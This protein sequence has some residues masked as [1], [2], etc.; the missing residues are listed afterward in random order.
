MIDAD[1][2]ASM[3]ILRRCL[4]NICNKIIKCIPFMLELGK[5]AQLYFTFGG[6][7]LTVILSYRKIC[8]SQFYFN[9]LM[10]S[11]CLVIILMI[12]SGGIIDQI[13]ASCMLISLRKRFV[14][15]IENIYWQ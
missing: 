5:A 6:A 3:G 9:W 1:V 10:F 13:T 8:F 11:L 4:F 2:G 15:N 7:P 12:I 14:L